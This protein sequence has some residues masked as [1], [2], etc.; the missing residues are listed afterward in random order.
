MSMNRYGQMALEY[1]REN[2]PNEFSTIPDPEQFFTAAGE[3]IAASV[4]EVRDQ[5]VGLRRAGESAEEFRH[6]S[7]Q[8]SATAAELVLADH[9]LLTAE[10]ERRDEGP[11]PDDPELAAY[12][13][14][15]AE[16]NEAIAKLYE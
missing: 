4:G 9:H 8:A 5:I 12:Q 13:R 15:L 10:P 16:A 2:L 6:R 11:T 1:Q 14:D 3:E 7:S